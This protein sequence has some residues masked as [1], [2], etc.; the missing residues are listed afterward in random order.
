M[1][2]EAAIA[3]ETPDHGWIEKLVVWTIVL[4]AGQANIFTRSLG[5]LTVVAAPILFLG[6]HLALAWKAQVRFDRKYVLV[7][8]GFSF[9]FL[10]STLKYRELHPLFWWIY[11]MSFS[12]VFIV[13]RS[14]RERFFEI[15]EDVLTKLTVLALFL[16]GVQLVAPGPLRSL[17]T[18]LEIFRSTV[19]I[20]GVNAILYSMQFPHESI[21]RNCGFAWEP[22]GYAAILVFGIFVNL[23]RNQL[24]W[25]GNKRLL[26]FVVALG[27]TQSTTG[28][29]SAGI[30]LVWFI[31]HQ[32]LW[33]VW[34]GIS[35]P[36]IMLA[37]AH[38][39][40]SDKIRE[41][42]TQDDRESIELAMENAYNYES[43]YSPQRFA[44]FRI[45]WDDFR[46][47]PILG[48]G[49]HDTDSWGAHERI[50]VIVVTGLGDILRRFGLVGILFFTWVSWASSRKFC[51][52][53][54]GSQWVL[55]G[56]V[57]VVAFSYSQIQQPL[58][59]AFWMSGIFLVANKPIQQPEGRR[60]LH[61]RQFLPGLAGVR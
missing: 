51:P 11:V 57:M 3:Q 21:P 9:Y 22:G 37:M 2:A 7:V 54:P 5:A 26:I 55:F 42:L 12:C 53:I 14:M 45:A 15:F 16:W 52:G 48:F 35:I 43:V 28:W 47:N 36:I 56:L 44:S 6:I 59:M 58:F 13:L 19:T 30:L 18:S 17:L 38:P 34:L 27:T 61:G 23:F 31:S 8:G 60:I 33:P 1:A 4:F 10:L 50:Q 39:M 40:M 46:R 32:R 41:S 20:G 24:K 29:I 49:G 25:N